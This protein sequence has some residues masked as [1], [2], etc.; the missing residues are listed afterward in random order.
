MVIGSCLRYLQKLKEKAGIRG[1]VK[2]IDQHNW[3]MPRK[4][5]W[6]LLICLSE[7]SYVGN[8]SYLLMRVGL[9]RIVIPAID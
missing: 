4:E 1:T 6:K 8:G 5:F 9:N 3:R 2:W 7:K